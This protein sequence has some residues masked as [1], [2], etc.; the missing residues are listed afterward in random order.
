MLSIHK[1]TP[2]SID[3]QCHKIIGLKKF[4]VFVR[5]VMT[6]ALLVRG[7]GGGRK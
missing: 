3:S 2:V 7:E 5:P 4:F 6:I 1:S